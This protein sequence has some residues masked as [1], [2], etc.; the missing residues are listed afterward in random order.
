MDFRILMERWNPQTGETERAYRPC[1]RE[2]I[3]YYGT[4]D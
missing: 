4:G 3:I 1:S 2:T